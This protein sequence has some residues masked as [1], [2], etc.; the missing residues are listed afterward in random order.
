MVPCDAFL[1][2]STWLLLLRFISA[3]FELYGVAILVAK[4][5][6]GGEI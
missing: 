2:F 1:K 6:A 3:L 5:S 4:L